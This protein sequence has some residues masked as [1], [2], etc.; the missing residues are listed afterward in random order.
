VDDDY[1]GPYTW[2]GD[3]LRIGDVDGASEA[4][5]D[6]PANLRVVRASGTTAISSVATFASGHQRHAG[7]DRRDRPDVG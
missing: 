1:T 6:L 2:T 5:Y 3:A 4:S 7:S